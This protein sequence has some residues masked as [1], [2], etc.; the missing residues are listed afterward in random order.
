MKKYIS[1]YLGTFILV[2]FGTGAIVFNTFSGGAVTHVGISLV[3]GMTV[4]LIINAIGDVSG[5]HLNPAVSIG[6]LVAG[7]AKLK[8][9]CIYIVFQ[10]LGALTAS[11]ILKLL[12]PQ[13]PLLGATLP[14][15][16]VSV[17]NAF[18]LEF[19]MTLVLM[20]VILNVSTGA[21]EKGIT[22]G[23]AIGAVI[24]VE[25]LLCGPMT[26]ASMNPARSIAPALISGN[27]QYLWV[28]ILAPI[29]GAAA[30]NFISI[31]ER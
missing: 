23:L 22:A 8:E 19:I 17:L 10:L 21:K 3:F 31:K 4:M 7:K 5:A 24:G 18:I 29:A 9:T 6:F 25:A 26:G 15:A 11:L 1:E 28:Y 16:G 13:D 20:Y 30:G 2:F 27:L 12:F 14:A